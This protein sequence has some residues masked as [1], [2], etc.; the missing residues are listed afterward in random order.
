MFLGVEVVSV[1]ARIIAPVK[2]SLVC[3]ILILLLPAIME[4]ISGQNQW[5][6]SGVHE[7]EESL[8]IQLKR[9]ENI[10]RNVIIFVGDGLDPNT[11]TASRFYKSQYWKERRPSSAPS[12]KDGKNEEESLLFEKFPNIGLLKTYAADRQV[13]D[14]ASTATALFCG[15]KANYET[16]GVDDTVQLGDC[17]ASLN[18]KAQV[19]SILKWALDSGKDAGFVTNMRVTHAT[20]SPLYAHTP[21][22]HWECDGK[23]PD[24]AKRNCKD[25]ARQLV[26]D[27]PGK[28]LKVIM[29]GGRQC[30]QSNV[31]DTAYDPIDRWACRRQDGLD[32]MKEWERDKQFR[33]LPYKVLSNAGDLRALTKDRNSSQYLLGIF[34]NGHLPYDYQRNDSDS[35]TPSLAEMVTAAIDALKDNPRGFVLAVEGGKIDV[36]HH[37]GTARKALDETVVMEEAVIAVVDKLSSS[38]QANGESPFGPNSRSSS[39]F[40]PDLSSD[41]LL[42][43]TSDHA[44]T[45]SING[46]PKRGNDILG[47]AAKSMMDGVDFTTL[48]YASGVGYHYSCN[49]SG[50]VMRSN[51]AEADTSSFDYVQQSAI[52]REEGTHGGGDVPVYAT[53]PMSH[54]FHRVHEQSYVAH[55]MAYAA[56]I[57]PYSADQGYLAPEMDCTMARK[58]EASLVV[59]LAWSFIGN[60]VI[61][62]TWKFLDLRLS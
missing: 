47:I 25:I 20:P 9:N 19:S 55:V 44:H 48:S 29:G 46:Y 24:E 36:A 41:T 1:P 2:M 50:V 26:E 15:V 8:K 14:S 59:P 22:R 28:N 61:M 34:A 32:L 40:W 52:W 7:L 45:M 60:V 51:P 23:M 43:V 53:G 12:K 18:P 5:M 21:E 13:P 6:A 42:I 27:E 3:I 31:V 49:K 10:A 62:F 37:R 54:L 39:S 11:V 56:R 35:G 30:L 38:T 57:G 33:G 16:A 4:A 17:E 58:S